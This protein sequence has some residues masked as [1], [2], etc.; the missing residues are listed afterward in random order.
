MEIESEP[1]IWRWMVKVEDY[2]GQEHLFE[3][4]ALLKAFSKAPLKEGPLLKQVTFIAKYFRKRGVPTLASR[5]NLPS[6]QA[7]TNTQYSSPILD[8][9]HILCIT[10]KRHPLYKV[11]WDVEFETTRAL[12][13]SPIR[14]EDFLRNP[15]KLPTYLEGVTETGRELDV[16]SWDRI[17]T[18]ICRV[19][20][21]DKDYLPIVLNWIIQ[22]M[23]TPAPFQTIGKLF[24]RKYFSPGTFFVGERRKRPLY[25]YPEDNLGLRK[26]VQRQ[27]RDELKRKELAYHNNYSIFV[28][29]REIRSGISLEDLVYLMLF[30]RFPDSVPLMDKIPNQ[31]YQDVFIK[32]ISWLV[33]GDPNFDFYEH[34]TER[35]FNIRMNQ[36][37]DFILPKLVNLALKEK[38]MIS[39][40]MG[41]VG[42]DLKSRASAASDIN[43]E[44]II[45]YY[46]PEKAQETPQ[47]RFQRIYN[48]LMEKSRQS[49]A[50]NCLAKFKKEVIEAQEKILLLIFH[51]D[52][53]ETKAD[54][55]IIQDLL[56][57]NKYLEAVSIPRSGVGMI[58]GSGDDCRTFRSG[59]RYGNDATSDNLEIVIYQPVY[60]K[61]LKFRGEGRYRISEWGPCWGGGFRIGS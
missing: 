12:K 15:S 30:L 24:N 57:I 16:E 36:V 58:Q 54:L 27:V 10:D 42:L 9:G 6:R 47:Q 44:N 18:A 2:S 53:F 49:L 41:L 56:E 14:E 61:L 1:G 19:L 3:A 35:E 17:E 20:N 21:I 48:E 29:V 59:F 4:S 39:I 31:I 55:L 22:P 8:A 7:L 37:A 60:K 13:S 33:W 40:A 28:G 26:W 46:H 52:W 5:F 38:I 51:D 25:L 45:Y 23:H 32:I 43:Y 50:I 34:P 11:S